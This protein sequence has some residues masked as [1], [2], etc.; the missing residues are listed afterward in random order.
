MLT[1]S[2]SKAVPFGGNR[3]W[4]DPGA[5]GEIGRLFKGH[6]FREANTCERCGVTK[7]AAARQK[8]RAKSGRVDETGMM[9][10]A[11]IKSADDDARSGTRVDALTAATRLLDGGFWPLWE[12]TPGRIVVDA[13]DRVCIYLSGSGTVVASARIAKV[14]PWTR[15][16]AAAY[17]LVLGGSPELVLSLVDIKFLAR[18]VVA[19]SHVD[20]LDCVGTNKRKWGAA[21]CGG[22][23]SLT[24]HDYHL[25][26]TST[27]ED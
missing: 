7:Q 27:A 9:H 21:F 4:C 18:P 22:M 24:A 15:A 2:K 10:F 8:A 17:P 23:R 16:I 11:L 20:K 13:G 12:N 19:A 26:T 1:E 25:L 6:L 3:A 14:Q 5:A